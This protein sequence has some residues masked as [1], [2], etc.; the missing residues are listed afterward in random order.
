MAEAEPWACPTCL[1]TVSTPYCPQCGERPLHA[2]ELTLRGFMDQLVQ[3]FTSIDGRLLR[4]FRCLIGRPGFLTVAYLHGQRKPYVGPIPLFLIANALF[5]ATEALMGGTV[6]T[7]PLDSH[8]NSQPWSAFAQV[9]ISHRL[10]TMQ[11]TRDLY[12]PVFDHAVARNAPSLIMLMALS[13]VVVPSIVFF[14]SRR[15]FVVHALFSLHVYAFVLVLLSVATAV[16]RV[17][18]WLGGAGFLSDGLDRVISLTLLL[19]CAIYLYVATGTVYGAHGALRVFKVSTLTLAMAAI[20]L[21]YRFA[22]LI[23]TLYST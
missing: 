16:P 5:F 10:E 2:R 9:L 12:A 21:G 14:R 20:V 22:L 13:F 8:L 1:R 7:T 19:A 23:V 4:S 6:F 17:D 18:A 15:P 11:T 3:A